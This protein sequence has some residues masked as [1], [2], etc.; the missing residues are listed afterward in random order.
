M[1]QSVPVE[2]P[3]GGSAVGARNFCERRRA[4]VSTDGSCR[5][6]HPAFEENPT[7]RYSVRLPDLAKRAQSLAF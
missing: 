7:R 5:V 1:P 6:Y 3:S 4:R 2:R